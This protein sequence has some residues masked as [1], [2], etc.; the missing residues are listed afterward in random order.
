MELATTA[1][2]DDGFKQKVLNFIDEK[3]KID[4]PVHD[5]RVANKHKNNYKDF[6]ISGGFLYYKHPHYA[7]VLCVPYIYDSSG[8]IQRCKRHSQR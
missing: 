5:V 3:L 8:S 7:D 6:Y 2:D 4:L 1:G